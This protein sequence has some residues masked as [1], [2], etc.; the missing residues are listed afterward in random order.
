[1]SS[2]LILVKSHLFPQFVNLNQEIGTSRGH[3]GSQGAR[4]Q[5]S[6]AD[7]RARHPGATYR[8][9]GG[10]QSRWAGN[11]SQARWRRQLLTTLYAYLQIFMLVG[12]SV[13]EILL[14]NRKKK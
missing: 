12:A 3:W 14:F 8:R 9:G 6:V 11:P 10:S 2:L 5:L 1:M 4:L 7:G 13:I